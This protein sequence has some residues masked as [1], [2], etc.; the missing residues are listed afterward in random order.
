VAYL[1]EYEDPPK[2][3]ARSSGKAAAASCCRADVADANIGNEAVARTVTQLG[4][5]DILREQRSLPG[6]RDEFLN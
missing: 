4:R 2:P 3:R 1:N 5:L 6:A